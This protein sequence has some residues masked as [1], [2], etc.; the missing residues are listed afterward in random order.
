MCLG[1]HQRRYILRLDKIVRGVSAVRGLGKEK[2]MGRD[3][4]TGTRR[5]G[6]KTRVRSLGSRVRVCEGG[7]HDAPRGLLLAGQVK[8]RLRTGHWVSQGGRHWRPGPRRCW[9][10]DR[11][12]R[13][14]RVG[15]RQN[16][17]RV[18]CCEKFAVK[19]SGDGGNNLI[20]VTGKMP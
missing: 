11:R 18:S 16:G 3:S 6:E 15:F 20:L 17:R 9:Q 1:G 8:F 10:A 4:E 13:L 5:I 12:G 7:R 14:S 2:G 19:G